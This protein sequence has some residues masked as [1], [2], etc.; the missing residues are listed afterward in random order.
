MSIE[1]LA[2]SFHYNSISSTRQY[3]GLKM[4]INEKE[5]NKWIIDQMVH[6]FVNNNVDDMCDM[7]VDIRNKEDELMLLPNIE[8]LDKIEGY[9]GL[10]SKNITLISQRYKYTE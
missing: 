2:I 1:I 5:A 7:I 3:F 4:F 8:L 9:F 10:N 6:L